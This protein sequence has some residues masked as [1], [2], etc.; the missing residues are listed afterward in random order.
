MA[1]KITLSSALGETKL[2]EPVFPITPI[3]Q[4]EEPAANTQEKP[5]PV[6]EQVKVSV[7][8]EKPE[9]TA[10]YHEQFQRKEA[11][12]RDDQIDWLEKQKRRLQKTNGYAGEF[13]TANTVLR[14]AI[15]HFKESGAW[16]KI[17]GSTEEEMRRSLGLPEI[18]E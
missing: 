13:V 4:P 5:A 11:R 10:R 2:D 16:R 3:A 14:L 17:E 15:D 12:L 8:D 6:T 1:K 7:K 18:E 9:K